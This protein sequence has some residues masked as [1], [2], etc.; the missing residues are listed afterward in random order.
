MQSP[1]QDTTTI[2]NH[3]LKTP[4]TDMQSPAQDTTTAILPPHPSKRASYTNLLCKPCNTFNPKPPHD[5]TFASNLLN[6][7]QPLHPQGEATSIGCMVYLAG[8]FER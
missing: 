3:L 6:A 5:V 1:A 7:P 4:Q 2:C 8:L